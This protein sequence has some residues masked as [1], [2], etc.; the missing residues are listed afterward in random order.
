MGLK[1]IA[2]TGAEPVSLSDVTN[3]IRY[4]GTLQNSVI[5]SLI[6]AAI[7]EVENWT[8]K[9]VV[10]KDYQLTQQQFTS[11]INFPVSTVQSITSIQ[12]LDSED[13]LQTVAS[14]VY[15]LD[16]I[17]EINQVFQKNTGTG[18]PFSNGEPNSVQI[19][20]TSSFNGDVV[21]EDTK[22]AI[23]IIVAHMYEEREAYSTE[24]MRVNP[25]IE[26]LLNI[27]AVYRF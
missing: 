3:W 11:I 1:V 13:N 10:E 24:A 9:T 23:K 17:S 4:T 22:T 20:F 19:N 8:N 6:T 14:S 21:P 2:V 5:T 12:Y 25:A 18:F 15:G 7:A 27:Q 26:N 16:N